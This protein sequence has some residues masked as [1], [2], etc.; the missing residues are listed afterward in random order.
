V[1][2]RFPG[3]PPPERARRYPPNARASNRAQGRGYAAEPDVL[4]DQLAR[5]EAI[6]EADT[7]RLTVPNQLGVDYNA[8]VLEAILKYVAPCASL[9]LTQIPMHAGNPGSIRRAWFGG[10]ENTLTLSNGLKRT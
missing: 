10:V 7:V 4:V 8:N 6:A 2:A 1:R 9:A 5:G 3:G